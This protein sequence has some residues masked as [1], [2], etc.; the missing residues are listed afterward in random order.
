MQEIAQPRKS[1][2]HFLKPCG[3]LWEFCVTKVDK[4]CDAC[5]CWYTHIHFL[6]LRTRDPSLTHCYTSHLFSSSTRLFGRDKR[7]EW[8]VFE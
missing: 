4:P 7:G 6:A 1:G 5:L 3:V 8:E 2:L